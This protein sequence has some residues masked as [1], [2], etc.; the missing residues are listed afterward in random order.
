MFK[1]RRF[2]AKIEEKPFKLATATRDLIIAATVDSL[3]IIKPDSLTDC[4]EIEIPTRLRDAEIHGLFVDHSGTHIVVSLAGGESWY[5]SQNG[6]SRLVGW[7]GKVAARLAFDD[8]GNPGSNLV[9]VATVCGS[10][11]ESR[12]HHRAR[13]E[14]RLVL[15]V[16]T[17]FSGLYFST[18]VAKSSE[19]PPVLFILFGTS[20]PQG[21]LYYMLSNPTQIS[22]FDGDSA[23]PSFCEIPFANSESGLVCSLTH[24]CDKAVYSFYALTRKGIFH[25]HLRANVESLNMLDGAVLEFGRSGYPRHDSPQSTARIADNFLF[26]YHDVIFVASQ[27]TGQIVQ[28]MKLSEATL[29]HARFVRGGNCDHQSVWLWSTFALHGFCLNDSLPDSWISCLENAIVTKKSNFQQT[30]RVCCSNVGKIIVEMAY[31]RFLE[32]CLGLNT[33]TRRSALHPTW[34]FEEVSRHI[35]TV[36]TSPRKFVDCNVLPKKKWH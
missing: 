1:L 26:M 20:R 33:A 25:G 27:S 16:N 2:N 31:I 3:V 34:S 6:L 12:L 8:C 4:Q 24:H 23:R 15:D 32:D 14:P 18:L 30:H 11:Y 13:L 29:L 22:R 10:I 9:L 35:T 19:T 17:V 5:R 7:D 36:G 28:E 21:R